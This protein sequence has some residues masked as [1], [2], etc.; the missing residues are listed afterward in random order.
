MEYWSDEARLRTHG[1]K[2]LTIISFENK[3]DTRVYSTVFMID[4]NL[5]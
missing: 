5:F 2:D 1:E 3:T 4:G